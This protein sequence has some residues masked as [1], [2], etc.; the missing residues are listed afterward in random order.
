MVVHGDYGGGELGRALGAEGGG[1]LSRLMLILM[2]LFM[3]LLLLAPTLLLTLTAAIA[4]AYA[5]SRHGSQVRRTSVL[6]VSM[7]WES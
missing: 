1:N 6:E 3:L 2:L 4:L 7:G 5:P